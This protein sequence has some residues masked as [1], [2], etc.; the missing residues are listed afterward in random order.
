MAVEL[1]PREVV[2]RLFCMSKFWGDP[3]MPADMPYPMLKYSID[4]KDYEYPLTFV[5]QLDCS[6]LQPYITPGLIPEEGMLY[7]FAAI[8][9]YLG[10]EAPG[11][12]PGEW[13]KGATM[14]KYT[15]LINPETF[16]S[17]ESMAEDGESDTLAPWAID[18]SVCEAGKDCFRMFGGNTSD[19]EVELLRIIGTK[20][21]GLDFGDAHE[22]VFSISKK[23]LGFGNW[24][25]HQVVLK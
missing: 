19:E 25:K 21:M 20:E 1:K 23:D 11:C 16:E 4:G 24:K 8:D 9:P 2:S 3:D 22:L 10:Y 15:K 18:F 7:F 6:D 17:Y 14:V 5:C 12:G 13:P